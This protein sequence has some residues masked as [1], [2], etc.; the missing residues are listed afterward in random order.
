HTPAIQRRQECGGSPTACHVPRDG[1]GAPRGRIRAMLRE[2]W[3]RYR[4]ALDALLEFHAERLP[5]ERE[6]FVAWWG[7]WQQS[8]GE[9]AFS[10]LLLSSANG[11]AAAPAEP[12]PQETGP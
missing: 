1:L 9:A 6:Q 12:A 11:R 8:G 4:P 2:R 3:K 5:R 7:R 10:S